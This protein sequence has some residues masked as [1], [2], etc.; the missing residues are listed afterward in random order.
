MRFSKAAL[1]SINNEA[2]IEE[3]NNFNKLGYTPQLAQ[4]TL[5]FVKDVGEIVFLPHR[6]IG[7]INLGKVTEWAPGETIEEAIQNYINR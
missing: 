6:K 4:F 2:V 7:K 5:P 3:Y 1:V